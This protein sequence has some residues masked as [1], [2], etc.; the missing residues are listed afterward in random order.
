MAGTPS[1]LL[2]RAT[3]NSELDM[4]F[5]DMLLLTFRSFMKPA[6]FFDELISRFNSELPCEPTADDI[7]YFNRIKGTVQ[8]KYGTIFLMYN[9]WR[10]VF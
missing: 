7:E 1:K 2:E 5:A 9:Y 4:T 8:M 6:D 10:D 3:D